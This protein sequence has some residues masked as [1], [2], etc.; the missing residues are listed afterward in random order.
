M[1]RATAGVD[2]ATLARALLAGDLRAP[3]IL[4]GRFGARVAR[5]LRLTVGP[6]CDVE[7]LV[8]EVFAWIARNAAMLRKS[9]SLKELVVRATVSACRREQQRQR[10]R[11]RAR[12]TKKR[13][14][15]AGKIVGSSEEVEPVGAFE[16][17][18]D[19]APPKQR[20]PLIFELIRMFER[21]LGIE[22]DGP[23][24]RAPAGPTIVDDRAQRRIV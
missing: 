13:T 7:T 18:L 24:D 22:P 2:D 16:A 21:D 9:R 3:A 10:R 11:R 1:R 14:R 23:L 20:A 19:E 12:I 5:I 4:R 17:L 8:E 6:E 15:V